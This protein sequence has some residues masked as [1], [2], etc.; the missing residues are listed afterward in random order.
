MDLMPAKDLINH[1]GTMEQWYE[2]PELAGH[3]ALVVR[4]PGPLPGHLLPS[5]HDAKLCPP[6]PPG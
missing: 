5:L 2:L 3:P 4:P 6:G 1:E